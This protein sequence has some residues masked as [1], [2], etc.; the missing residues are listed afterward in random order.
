MSDLSPQRIAVI[1]LGSNTARLVV[2]Q[3]IPGYSYRLVDQIREVVRLRQGMT[4]RGLSEQAERRAFS[5][6]RLFTRFCESNDVDVILPVATSAVRDAANGPEFVA[7]VMEEI[8]IRLRVLSGEQEAFYGVIGV[9]NEVPTAR[10]YVLDIGGG[11]AQIS[12]VREGKFRRGDALP[13]GALALTERFIRRD[14]ATPSECQAVEAEIERQ[15]DTFEWLK[16]RENATLIGLGGTI[17]NLARIEAARQRYPLTTLHGFRLP[18]ASVEESIAQFR[19]LPLRERRKIPGL[20]GDRGDIILPGAMVLLA[21]MRRLEVE[22]ITISES[23][24]REGVFLE[25]FWQHLPYPVIPDVRRFSVLNMARTYNYHKS[26]AN[27][28]R[29]LSLRI[30]E[31]LA[32]LHGYGPA[33]REWLDAAALL[34]DL[35]LAVGYESHHK[36]SQTLIE[37]NGLAGFS[38]REIAIISLLTRYHRKGTPRT[39]GYEMLLKEGD[40]AR[41]TR[42]AAILRLAEYLERSRTAT[43]DDVTITWN[44]DT[45]RLTLIADEYPAVEMWQTERHAL[46]LMEKAFEKQVILDSLMPPTMA[47]GGEV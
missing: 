6:L 39:R 9:L 38:P 5:T 40:K 3:A 32:P 22:A 29:F 15:L 42:L 35:G 30:F 1:D 13:L 18:R 4:A 14:P 25:K 34:H 31:Q 2:M 44:E 16:A 21:L 33:E 46:E 28:V 17:R 47:W 36:H 23:G 24:L 43:V 12:E 26:H 20:D 11:S 8:G 7:R 45:L 19:S 41:I 37:H 10:G 27:H